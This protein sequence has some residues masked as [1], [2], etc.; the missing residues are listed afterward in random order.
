MA[1]Q[2]LVALV[3]GASSGFGRMIARD[4]AH[5]AHSRKPATSSSM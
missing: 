1:G 2:R 5:A 4:L 3:T